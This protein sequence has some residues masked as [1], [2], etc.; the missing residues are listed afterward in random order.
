M[1]GV[2]FRHIDTSRA[3]T[4]DCQRSV[5][6]S[7]GKEVYIQDS[8]IGAFL[9]HL[10]REQG[11]ILTHREIS[12]IVRGN[13]SRHHMEDTP[14]NILANK[15]VFSIRRLLEKLSIEN[16]IETV[17]TRGYKISSRWM[18]ETP[19]AKETHRNNIFLREL[20]LLIDDCISYCQRA[21]IT[22]DKS[23]LSFVVPEHNVLMQN[24]HRIN[25]C[26]RFF[27]YTYSFPGNSLDLLEIREK[28][29]RILQY[30]IYWRIG[31]GLSDEKYKSDYK[32]EL[33]ILYRQIEHIIQLLEK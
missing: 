15:T 28:L 22:Q 12:D 18:R 20:R 1:R 10:F 23:G 17:R 29:I 4:F 33:N 3:L 30:A 14:D 25:N 21:E 7:A 24:F 5:L 27:I 19:E 2:T 26:Y 11:K 8:A 13:K 31:D 16:F 9:L 32:E 6:G